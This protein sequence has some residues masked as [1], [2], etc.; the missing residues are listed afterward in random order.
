MDYT[1]D[2]NPPI[3]LRN[4]MYTGGQPV[5]SSMSGLGSQMQS[6]P[7]YLNSMDL[8]Y[9]ATYGNPYLTRSSNNSLPHPH[10]INNSPTANNS[11]HI[12]NNH[13][14]LNNVPTT[15]SNTSP[16]LHTSHS[17]ILNSYALRNG[18]VPQV[19]RAPS[20]PSPSQYIVPS[21]PQL[22]PGTLATH[23]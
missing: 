7:Q 20:T 15:S 14:N 6:P 17:N 16:N 3:S 11:H 21:Q 9:S 23:V 8:R 22:K 5:V 12:L 10:L 19:A 4:S 13:S 2:Y 18:A 1:R